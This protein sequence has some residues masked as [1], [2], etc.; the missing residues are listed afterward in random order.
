MYLITKRLFDKQTGIVAAVFAAV[1]PW[2]VY[3]SRTAYEMIPAT[4]FIL[5]SIYYI[6]D[7][8]KKHIYLAIPFL[9]LAFYSYIGTKLIILPLILLVVFYARNTSRRKN[10]LLPH[11]VITLTGIFLVCFF[12]LMQKGQGGS[13]MGDLFLPSDSTIQQTVDQMRKITIDNPV[14][15]VLIN[16]ATVYI[17]TLAGKAFAAFSPTYLFF[18]GDLF[19]SL[20]HGFLYVIDAL[21]I[22][23][24]FIFLAYKD[25]RLG[26]FFALLLFLSIFPQLF[27]K[28]QAN[29]SSHTALLIPFLIILSA[30]GVRQIIGIFS[31]KNIRRLAGLVFAFLYLGCVVYFL[32]TYFFRYPL[33]ERNEFHVRTLSRYLKLTENR[34]TRVFIKT[35]HPY[36]VFKK[37]VFYTN[38]IQKSSIPILRKAYTNKNYTLGNIVFLPCYTDI[39]SDGISSSLIIDS[40]CSE[41]IN[42]QGNI[43]I[44]RLVDGGSSYT[45]YFDRICGDF[46]LKR[47]PYGITWDD[48]SVEKMPLKKFCETYISEY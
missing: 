38:N 44:A 24:G 33:Q 29:F 27:H 45:I 26:L 8:Q 17:W 34:D 48:L 41:T 13:R 7:K 36:N 1:N 21:F 43:H 32:H 22:C 18:E 28:N 15:N 30:Y 35:P 25:K 14:R 47:Y 31:S 3:M 46:S 5:S 42:G 6:L 37:Y 20:W 39:P 11:I 10:T 16:K 23:I 40:D 12:V 9:I 2:L 4:L 19:F